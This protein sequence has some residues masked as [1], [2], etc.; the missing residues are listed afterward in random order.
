M[1]AKT[2]A[3]ESTILQNLLVIGVKEGEIKPLMVDMC[4]LCDEVIIC[5]S[6]ILSS[7][8]VIKSKDGNM[9]S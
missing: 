6:T 4:P 7:S 8:I 3:N 9:N 1:L 2:S 5:W